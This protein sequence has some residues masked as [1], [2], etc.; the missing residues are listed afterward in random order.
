MRSS[1]STTPSPR[2]FRNQPEP[3]LAAELRSADP[4]EE[5]AIEAAISAGVVVVAANGNEFGDG[6]SDGNQPDY[7]AGYPNVIAVGASAVGTHTANSYSSITN[8]TVA[9][10]SNAGP[11]LVAPGGDAGNDTTGSDRLLWIEGYSTTTATYPPDQC[12]D[13]GGVCRVLFN[14]TSQATPQV[15]AAVALMEAYHGGKR[16]LSPATVTSILTSTADNIGGERVR[17]QA[18]ST[19]ATR[20][21]QPTP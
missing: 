13:S 5:N 12:T 8:E 21:R 7:P 1:R 2:R 20:W 10:Y 3:R 18:A 16:S 14:G 4:A 17:A 6:T 15:A 9:S 19:P 11:T